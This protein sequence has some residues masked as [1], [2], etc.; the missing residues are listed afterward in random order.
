MMGFVL[1]AAEAVAQTPPK[2]I[3]SVLEQAIQ[4]GSVVGA[5]ILSGS[6]RQSPK[7]SVNLGVLAPDDPRPVTADSMFCIASCSKPL[8]SAVIFALVDQQKLNLTTP[9]G[10]WMKDFHQPRITDGTTTRSPNLRE[11]LSHRGGIYSQK[12]G[13]NEVQLKAIR[14]FQ[15]TLAQSVELIRQQ[16]LISIPGKK[17]AY[18]GAGYC[19]VG[20]TAESVSGKP[21]DTLLQELLCIP[22]NMAST[23]FFPNHREGTEIASG[24]FSRSPP[25]HLLGTEMRLPLVGGSIHTTAEDLQ[26]FARMVIAGGAADGTQVLSPRSWTEYVSQP[27]KE[28]AYGYGWTRAAVGSQTT[29][30]HNGSLPPAQAAM[31]I[32]LVTGKYQIVLWTLANPA[33]GNLTANIRQQVHSALR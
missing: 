5:Q 28:Q 13:L 30:S 33:N 21:I 7:A 3:A 18:S 23:T 15:L 19:L 26:K 31:R 14:D 17:Y 10:T 24:G 12:S 6:G 2:S 4:Q 9:I 25:P 32:N 11:L 22:A 1:C 27:F 16:P 8:I 29:L 20:A